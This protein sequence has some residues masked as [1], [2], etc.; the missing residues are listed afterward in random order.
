MTL[1]IEKNKCCGC[2]ACAISCPK[3]CIELQPD[4]E[5]F[6]YP[7]IDRERCVNCGKCQNVCPVLNIKKEDAEP[8][9][10]VGFSNDCAVRKQS[11]SGGIFTELAKRII[12]NDGIVYGAGFDSDYGVEHFAVS[13]KEEI[14]LLRGSKYVQSRM[15]SVYGEI[16]DHLKHGKLVYFSGTPCQVAGLY[17]FL[18]CRPDNLITQDLI[19]HGVGSP[20]VW[21][22]YL[23][24]YGKIKKAEFRNKKYGWHYF[25]MHIETEK[26]RIYK[27]LD[28]DAYLRLFLDNLI[29]RPICYD[30]PVKKSRSKADITLAD[31]WSPHKVT[32]AVVDY[33]EGLSLMIANTAK[34]KHWIESLGEN[35]SLYLVDTQKALNSQNALS[36]SVRSPEQ[37]DVFFSEIN[38][39]GFSEA[40][41]NQQDS[42]L[43]RT[44]KTRYIF[45]K[46]RVRYTLQNIRKD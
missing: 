22:K 41:K 27:R 43:L 9:C 10:Y 21:Q 15:G 30:C 31:C 11:S 5:G 16:K 33:D 20:M 8:E 18:G 36:Q 45:M 42:S 26:K 28:E 14:S 44:V 40:C 3:K 24:Q 13:T 17:S 32:D 29:L 38:Q 2:N 34:G 39:K 1:A 23:E 19:C 35:A 46:T 4:S 12:E 25:S 7:K 6:L 37:R